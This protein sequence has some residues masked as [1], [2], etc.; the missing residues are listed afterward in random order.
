M[1]VSVILRFL[2]ELKAYIFLIIRYI[3][4][5]WAITEQSERQSIT[6]GT[7]SLHT[8]RKCFSPK[9]GRFKHFGYQ[10][11]KDLLE[12]RHSYEGILE[13]SVTQNF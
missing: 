8:S 1:N 2:H 4:N 12:I 13:G 11:L 3:A 5:I 6:E 9:H 7:I 10:M